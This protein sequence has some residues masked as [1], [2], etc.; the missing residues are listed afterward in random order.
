MLPL[1]VS[2]TIQSCKVTKMLIDGG[3]ILN[4]LSVKALKTL[5]IPL[6]CLEPTGIFQGVNSRTTQ[7]LGQVV[8]PG[9]RHNFRTEDIVFDIDDTPLPY[10]SILRS[11]A[12]AKFM[13]ASHYAYNVLKMSAEWEVLK[14]KSDQA[15]AILCINNLNKTLIAPSCER[16]GELMYDP[17]VYPRN[18]D[19][20]RVSSSASFSKNP[21]REDS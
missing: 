16:E 17:E 3:S 8:L 2:P 12:L 20:P 19:F 21:F 11:P 9:D 10:S 6:S 7:P 13:E 15:D 5:Q 14:V 1:I 4:L 18:S